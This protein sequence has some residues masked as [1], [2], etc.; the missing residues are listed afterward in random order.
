M[1]LLDQVFKVRDLLGHPDRWK[2]YNDLP[3]DVLCDVVRDT[4]RSDLYTAIRNIQGED[5]RRNMYKITAQLIREHFPNRLPQNRHKTREADVLDLIRF[6]NH[7][8]TEHKDVM[9]ILDLLTE[10]AKSH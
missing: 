5:D 2:K 10:Y 7:K 1:N 9:R 6:N 3:V 8:D 4:I